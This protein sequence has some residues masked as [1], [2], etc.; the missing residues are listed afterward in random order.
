MKG[1]QLGMKKAGS[2]LSRYS[3]SCSVDANRWS[4]MH[5]RER[6]GAIC[7]TCQ[8]LEPLK[9]ITDA[10]TAHAEG[11]SKF[12]VVAIRELSPPRCLWRDPNSW[13]VHW[14]P[15]VEFHL[16]NSYR[17]CIYCF[18]WGLVELQVPGRLQV[19]NQSPSWSLFVLFC[20][21][22]GP[23]RWVL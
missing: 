2:K 21:W 4:T 7:F 18:N 11:S 8:A 3:C 10:G 20:R 17:T 19:E 5:K 22:F 12:R 15:N 23:D 1:T 14:I 13:T 9:Q 16:W 6:Q